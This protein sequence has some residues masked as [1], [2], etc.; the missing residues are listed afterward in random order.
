M[1]SKALVSLGDFNR[2]VNARIECV[3]SIDG[4]GDPEFERILESYNL[5]DRYKLNNPSNPVWIW[6]TKDG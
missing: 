1:K 6:S 2:I 3:G 4:R 5:G